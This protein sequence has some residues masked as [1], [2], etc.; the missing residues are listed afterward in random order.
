MSI[1]LSATVM[2]LKEIKKYTDTCMSSPYCSAEREIVQD[3]QKKGGQIKMVMNGGPKYLRSVGIRQHFK[4]QENRGSFQ[5][6]IFTCIALSVDGLQEHLAWI[7]DIKSYFEELGDDFPY[8]LIADPQRDLAVSFGMLNE[9]DRDNIELG[10]TIRT[11][12]VIDPDHKVRLTM[13]YPMTTGRNIDEILRV[14]DSMQL[15]DRSKILATPVNWTPG[16]KVMLIP[17]VTDEEA[18]KFFSKWI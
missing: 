7:S 18:K 5:K 8:P 14:I 15:T 9:D 11:V 3:A 17:S 6:K 13:C 4:L 1:L 10:K 12:Y 2:A 16:S